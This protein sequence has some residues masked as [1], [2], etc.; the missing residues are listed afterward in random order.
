MP[1]TLWLAFFMLSIALLLELVAPQKLTEGFQNLVP[2]LS[3]RQSY[4]SQFIHK[5]GDVGPNL[6]QKGYIQD[7][8][9]FADFVDVQ[10]YGVEQ[11]FCRMV[12]PQGADPSETFFAC[13]L[14]GTKDISTTLYK[15]NTVAQGLKLSRDDYMRDL[16]KDGRASYCRVMKGLDGIYQPLCRRALDLGFSERDEVDPDPPEDVV[17]LVSFYEG[18]VIWLRMRDDLLDYVKNIEAQRG[19]SITIDETPRPYPVQGLRFDG[20]QQFLRIGD[21]PD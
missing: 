16:M 6:E 5:R 14:G 11:D 2:V 21:T 18:C 20:G 19:G 1:G 12:V 3:K 9:Y 8:R 15:T 4:F 13:A 10:R 7:R 17:K